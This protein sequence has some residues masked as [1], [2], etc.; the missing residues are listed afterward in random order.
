M[1]EM[2]LEPPC[3]APPPTPP[4]SGGA[5]AP[6]GGSLAAG[7][8]LAW[9]V[10]VVGELLVMLTGSLGAILGGIGLPPLAV[11]VW[12]F[13][14]LGQGKSRTGKGMFLGLLSVIAVVLLL[15][16]ACFGLMSNFH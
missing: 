13:V 5:P 8:G 14:L 1:N 15:V 4:P 6:P 9:L 16:A 12:A 11:I 2:R 7:V 10:M 3:S